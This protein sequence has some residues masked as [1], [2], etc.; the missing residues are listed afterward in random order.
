M[1][2]SGITFSNTET[3]APL[4]KD[5]ASMVEYLAQ[6]LGQNY[7]TVGLEHMTHKLQAGTQTT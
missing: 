5:E 7:Y 2:R 6:G 1:W 4:S 3:L